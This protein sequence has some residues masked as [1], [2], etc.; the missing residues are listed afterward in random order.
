MWHSSV[1]LFILPTEILRLEWALYVEVAFLWAMTYASLCQPNFL[2]NTQNGIISSIFSQDS[3]SHLA[4]I[5]FQSQFFFPNIVLYVSCL[6]NN[7]SSLLSFFLS[8][9][10]IKTHIFY[11]R[12]KLPKLLMLHEVHEQFPFPEIP[13]EMLLKPVLIQHVS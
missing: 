8:I 3:H 12:V 5:I 2:A 1:A 4:C 13:S 10:L 7:Y 11:S 6:G 9:Y